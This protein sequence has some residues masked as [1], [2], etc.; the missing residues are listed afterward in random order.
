MFKKK[1]TNDSFNL[2]L[3]SMI[4]VIFLLLI[5]FMCATQIKKDEKI[6]ISNLPTGLDHVPKKEIF[7]IQI[8]ITDDNQIS[9]NVMVSVN[10]VDI[11][12]KNLPSKLKS[13]KKVAKDPQV[14]ILSKPNIK[15]NNIMRI[16][17][18]C[19]FEKIGKISMTKIK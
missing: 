12:L 18:S 13:L 10:Q 6:I 19:A 15:F 8:K 14:K 5:F 16:L 11:L 2:D 1:N 7:K 17:D 3:T 4:D 9:E